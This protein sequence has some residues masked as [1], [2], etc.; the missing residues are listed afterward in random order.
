MNR[1][2]TG[3][4][5]AAGLARDTADACDVAV[6]GSGAGGAV[7]AKEL[8][9]GGLRVLIVEEGGYH[10]VHR[11]LAHEAIGRMYRD[12]G[13]TA[14]LGHPMIPVPMGRCVGGTTTINSGTCFRTPEHVLVRWR[15]E[16]GVTD[17][18]TERMARL[19]ARVEQELHVEPADLA[20][21]SRPNTL[22]GEL[23]DR[24]GL[25]GAALRRNTHG[26]EGC[27][28]C[29]YGCTSGGKKAMPAS[30]LPKALKAGA[31]L[32]M[33]ARVIRIRRGCGNA[34]LGLEAAAGANRLTIHA[35]I[36][37]VACGTMLTPCLL[38]DNGIARGNPHLGRH[39][40]IHPASK[41]VGEFDE[42]IDSW[43]GIPQAYSYDGLHDDGIMFE[44]ITMP[45]DLGGAAVPFTGEHLAHYIKNY[46]HM[47]PF[48]FLISDTAEGRM[49]RLPFA[50][51][52]FFYSLTPTDVRRIKRA[53][54]FLARLFL[55][56][57]AIR[58]YAMIN[59]RNNVFSDRAD[60]D[61][62]DRTELRA[63]DIEAMAFHPLGTCRM[64]GTPSRGV[65]DAHQQVF[66]TPGLYLCDGSVVP[67][68]LG[69]NPQETIMALATR[70]AEHLLGKTLGPA[71]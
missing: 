69:V 17:L 35:P 44:G 24:A 65:C 63:K 9:E 53:I 3:I 23:L 6:I 56:G 55:D 66:D 13:I 68:P 54:C 51:Y 8:A 37:I 64:A 43:S 58:T 50:G 19:F 39:L 46:A 4:I 38:R 32:Y 5:D 67:T 14:T 15:G 2:D 18:A 11:D 70:L 49:R 61:R 27:G 34:V 29:C 33:N 48:G 47:A 36:V 10:P 60:V 20:V 21:M 22:T 57:G 16:F 45:P 52:R 42:R 26:C 31:R 59:S 71:E 28:M 30:Y 62:F 7:V 1:I 12:A 25:R 41:V 40:T